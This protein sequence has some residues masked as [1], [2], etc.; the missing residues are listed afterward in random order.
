MNCPC[1]ALV[2]MCSC[3]NSSALYPHMRVHKYIE[4]HHCTASQ[5]LFLLKLQ[6]CHLVEIRRS[7]SGSIKFILLSFVHFNKYLLVST[8]CQVIFR[9]SGYTRR[10]DIVSALKEQQHHETASMDMAKDMPWANW[11][12][13]EALRPSGGV[14]FLRTLQGGQ[15][16]WGSL[17]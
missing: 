7:A 16:E 6:Q 14:C 5:F 2:Y 17:A 4:H 11:G 13:E 1:F 9:L 12:V 3:E 10:Q 8:L 15:L